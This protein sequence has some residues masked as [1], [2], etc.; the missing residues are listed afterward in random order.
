MEARGLG[1]LGRE[2]ER[3][4]ESRMRFHFT[5]Y[6][7]LFSLS[8]FISYPCN[9]SIFSLRKKREKGEREASE[10]KDLRFLGLTEKERERDQRER[11]REMGEKERERE[12]EDLIPLHLPYQLTYT[13]LHFFAFAIMAMLFRFNFSLELCLPEG[14]REKESHLSR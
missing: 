12:R 3:G 9:S 5:L 10:H 2:R 1:R 11:E 4:R 14:L 7:S 8:L 13:D 6:Q